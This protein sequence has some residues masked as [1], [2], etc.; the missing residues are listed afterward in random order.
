MSAS[1]CY[2]HGHAGEDYMNM[3]VA[4]M[5]GTQ[6]R[7]FMFSCED[8]EISI[9]KGV[10]LPS[11]CS[12]FE[13]LIEKIYSNWPEGEN[14][15]KEISL[16]VFAAAGP[17]KDGRIVMTN[18]SFAVDEAVAEAYFP[19][20]RCLIMNDFEAQAWACLTPVMREAEN[21]LPGRFGKKAVP[22]ALPEML[23]GRNGDRSPVAVVGA[24]T[25]LGAAWLLPERGGQPFV[26]PS[27]AGHVAF[28]FDA[29]EEEQQFLRFLTGRR[30]GGPV[31]AE[32]V[33]S[34]PGLAMLHEHLHGRACEPSVFTREPEFADSACCRLFARFYGRFCR[35]AALALLPRALVVTGGVA[36]RTPALVR[37]PEFAREFLR[38]RGE[39]RAFLERLPVW[40]NRHPQSGLWGAAR[41]GLA[42]AETH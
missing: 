14:K 33:L 15:L 17:V 40:L 28:P 25:G 16:L 7:F 10:V 27:E 3:L 26:L 39:Q 23:S 8:K 35:T 6:S 24:G 4:D 37:H 9:K 11:L 18:A 22:S 12:S 36:G 13:A 5:G 42:F 38:A 31:T 34:G 2:L 41:A 32:H 1:L 21:L 30:D 19:G 29:D 20:V